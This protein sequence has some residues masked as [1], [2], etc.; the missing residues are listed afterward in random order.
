MSNSTQKRVFVSLF[1]ALNL[2]SGVTVANPNDWIRY[3]KGNV[4]IILV[5][6]HGGSET[7]KNWT[8]RSN[9]GVLN[10]MDSYTR[11]LS[12][13]LH[14]HLETDHEKKAYWVLNTV[15]RKFADVNR[16]PGPKAYE[17]PEGKAVYDAF[18]EIVD[19]AVREAVEQ[20]GFAFVVDIHG[21]S[22]HPA[23]V[24]LGTARRNSMGD[25]LRHFGEDVLIGPNS[26]QVL[27]SE[28]SY[29]TPP[30]VRPPGPYEIPGGVSGGYITHHYG[31]RIDVGAVQIEVHGRLRKNK[32][33]L[34]ILAKDLAEV[35]ADFYAAYLT[36]M[37]DPPSER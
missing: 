19:D 7:P 37:I 8:V 9:P 35:I 22:K 31:R 15:H 32:T 14:E 18:H 34:P 29:S 28:K 23:D 12:Q 10:A 27:L 24:Y 21:Q 1:A 4:P 13:K 2:F 20:F 26:L 36:E 5:T 16:D 33:L 17:S 3:E 11:P 25:L 6:G 30:S